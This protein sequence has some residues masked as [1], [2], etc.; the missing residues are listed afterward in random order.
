M[1][2]QPKG[3]QTEAKNNVLDI[4]RYANAQIDAATDP[5]SRRAA[6]AHNGCVLIQAPT[7]A[8]K[9]LIAGLVAQELSR[10]PDIKIVWLWFTPFAGLVEQARIAIKAEFNGLRVRDI[11][12]ERRAHGTRSGDVFVSTWAAVAGR[13]DS[14]RIRKDGDESVSLDLVLEQWRKDGFKIGVIVD[15]AHHT[16]SSGTESVRYYREVLQPDFTLMIT[17]TPDDQDAESFRKSA[18]IAVMHRITVSRLDAVSAGLIKPGIKSVAYLA[19]EQ[20]RELV[21]FGQAALADGVR[22]HN[23]IKA[24]LVTEGIDL[25]PLMLVQVAS[26][27]KS[28]EKAKMDL[29]ALGMAEDAIAVYTSKEPDDDLLAVARDES[30][31]A[32]IFKM[33]VALGFDAPRAF[34]LVSMRGA[35]DK[36][37]GT[38]IVGRILRVDWRLQSRA[39]SELLKYGYVFLA[40]AEKQA[41]LSGAADRI[42]AVR[43]ELAKISPFTM[44]VRMGDNPTV[45]VVENGQSS[46]LPKGWSPPPLPTETAG[47]TDTVRPFAGQIDLV[48]FFLETDDDHPYTR[49]ATQGVVGKNA[50]GMKVYPLRPGME[51]VFKREQLNLDTSGLL[52]AVEARIRIDDSVFTAG[53]RQAVSIQRKEEEIFTHDVHYG[54]YQ[55]RLSDA[56]IARRAQLLLFEPDYLDPRELQAALLNRLR[57]ECRERGFLEVLESPEKLRQAMHLILVS[58]PK[59]LREAV[60]ICCAENAEL[61]D[62]APLPEVMSWPTGCA[63]ERLAAY[64]AFPPDLNKDELAFAQLLDVEMSGQIVWWHRNEPRKPWSAGLV[65][66]DGTHYYPDFLVKIKGRTRGDGILL[67]EVKGEHLINSMNTPDKAAASHKLYSKPLMVMKENSGRWMTLRYN[68][69]TGKNEPDAI[70]R[71]DALAEY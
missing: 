56:E 5:D 43:S 32:L 53:F 51:R 11:A 70:F 1:I 7:G 26:T 47:G 4:F 40:D 44:L 6:I 52:R 29:M 31:E 10:D 27:D 66:P 15:E 14:K 33:A 35:Q 48:G 13:K 39:T 21:D 57:K 50:P 64:Q 49:A 17:A 41:G 36:D 16:F 18:G 65:M 20:H 24:Q 38:Q 60:R 19:G 63:V 42:N 34:T 22:V 54:E 2:A 46:F 67:I 12:R 28:V 62:T 55:A 59:L 68:D 71:L 8:G 69:R 25:V 30:K 45:Q 3:Y 58:H 23:A 61:V 9:T 37:F